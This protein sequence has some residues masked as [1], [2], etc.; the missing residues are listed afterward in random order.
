MKVNTIFSSRSKL[1]LGVPQRSVLGPLSFNIYF[2]DLFYLTEMTNLCNYADDTTFHA[3][4]LDLK[5][6]ITRLEHDTALAIEWF[7]SNYMILNQDKCHFLFS[8]HKYETLFVG[9]AKIWKSKQ[10]KLLGGLIDRNSKFDEYVLMQ[11]KKAGKK[12]N[13]LIRISKFMTFAQGR[14]IMKAFIESQFIYCPL[15]W[16]FCG[17]QTNA[18][19][20]HIHERTLKAVYSNEISSFQALLGR[21]KSETMYQ[22][23]S[24][25]LAAEF[26]KIKNYLWNDIMA[27]LICKS[28]SVGYKLCSQTGFSLIQV[29]SVTYR[30]KALRYFDLR[31]Y[32]IFF[33]VILIILE[34]FK[35][36]KKKFIRGFREIVLAESVKIPY[37]Q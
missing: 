28:N 6:F 29:K 14:N 12:L 8:G 3:C 32:G 16:M 20:N 35:Y 24:E 13:G 21:D 37:I 15:V 33:L 10:Q 19:I 7:E 17:R 34:H 25:I 2:N 4:D 9:K 27:K 5:S 31:E 30:V 22:G 36:S 23:N 18:R 11:C 26:F 1:V